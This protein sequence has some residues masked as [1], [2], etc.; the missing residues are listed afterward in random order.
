MGQREVAI[1]MNRWL[2]LAVLFI[3]RLTMAF[4]FQSIGALSPFIID[5]YALDLANIGLLV[6]LYLAPGVFVAIPGGAIASRF[7]DKRIVG[8]GMVLMLIGSAMPALVP[9]WHSLVAGRLIAG[10]GGVVLNVVMTKMLVDW[11]SGKEISTALG[12]FVNSW[13]AGIALAL[14]VLP[15]ISVSGNLDLAW[16]VTTAFILIG[17][18]MFMVFYRQAPGAAT[19]SIDISPSK[20]PIYPLL[21]ASSIWAL[22]NA[23]LAMVFSFGPVLLNEAG[24]SVAEA[25][26]AISAFMIIFSLALPVGGIIADHT[27]KRD[28]MILISIA[29]FA[30][31]MP[32]V[33]TASPVPLVIIL[34]AVGALFALAAGP[35]MALPSL[36]LPP[37]I[38]TLGMGVFFTVYYLVMMIAPRFV[39]GLADHAGN[40]GVAVYA[41][42]GMC[43]ASMIALELFRRAVRLPLTA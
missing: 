8:L 23:A 26:T 32:F 17:Y 36:V 35:I 42:V 13:P 27:G 5:Q 3:A 34:I 9:G 25:G 19:V 11:F 18:L 40:S 21:L 20:L 4:Q 28:L 30:I 1:M 14:L 6:G 29:S 2:I 39:G 31:L 16:W 10:V 7:G 37:N 22:Y 24:W 15:T 43:L 33:P 12:I 41:G 38:R